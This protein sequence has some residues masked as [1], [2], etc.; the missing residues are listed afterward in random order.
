MTRGGHNANPERN[1][2]IIRHWE[3]GMTYSAV[4]AAMKL[5]REV[6]AGV[7]KRAVARGETPALSQEDLAKRRLHTQRHNGGINRHIH[8]NREADVTGGG[9]ALA[10]VGPRECRFPIGS[11]SSPT[12]RFCREPR[13][14]HSPYC[15]HHKRICEVRMNKA[16]AEALPI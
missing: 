13:W 4:A 8:R 1:A 9:A 10:E 7:V 11:P 12:F 2:E 15:A 14:L 5:T 3:S 6:V 16:T